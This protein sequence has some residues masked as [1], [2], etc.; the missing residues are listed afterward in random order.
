LSV[1]TLR[2]ARLVLRRWQ[3]SDV[4]PMAGFNADPEVMRWIGDGTV[5][6]LDQTRAGIAKIEREWEHSGYGLFAV[7]LSRT[8]ELAGFAGLTVPYFLPELMPTVEI[9]WRLGRQFWGQGIATEAAAAALRFGLITRDIERIVS[10]FQIGNDASERVMVKLGMSFD[11]HTVD[12]GTTRP[13]GVYAISQDD[14][15]SA[16]FRGV[17][18]PGPHCG[19]SAR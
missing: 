18:P 1:T 9:G 15:F 12:P 5:R 10:I 4:E 8:G 14:Y 7:E 13:V 19:Q 16:G 17:V 6:D 3:E 11:R 2:T